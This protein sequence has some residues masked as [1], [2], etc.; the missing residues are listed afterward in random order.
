MASIKA[1]PSRACLEGENIL[2]C[3]SCHLPHSASATRQL[4]NLLQ[5]PVLIWA[6]DSYQQLPIE[7]KGTDEVAVEVAPLSFFSVFDLSIRSFGWVKDARRARARRRSQRE[8][9]YRHPDSLG[10]PDSRTS[11]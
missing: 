10:S 9:V 1:W 8:A 4:G 5:M 6:T 11:S 3:D 7:D 2:S